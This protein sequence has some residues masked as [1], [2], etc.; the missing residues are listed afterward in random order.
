[1]N[2]SNKH[3][4]SHS[5]RNI[6]F[7]V[8]GILLA[9]FLS[10]NESFH[11]FLLHLDGFGYIGA[12]IGGML[13]VSTFTVA[14]G[15]L[16]L[17]ILSEKISPVEIGMIAGFGAVI[18]DVII[19]HIVKDT[20]KDDIKD[21]YIRFG[22]KHLSHVL[23]TKYFHWTLPVIGALIIASPLPDELGV[24][25]MGIAKMNTPR[26]IIVSFILNAIGIFLVVSASTFIKP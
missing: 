20:L 24:G 4:K 5:Q 23:H 16:L 22:G 14:T 17:L 6:L 1:M 19:F 18:S 12:F 2:K 21:L 15:A 8:T 25:L 26:F 3:R 13:F 7:I 9:L 11:E 10:K